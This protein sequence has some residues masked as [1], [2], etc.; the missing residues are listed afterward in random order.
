MPGATDDQRSGRTDM[1]ASDP[2]APARQTLE[3]AQE[4]AS[5]G[6]VREDLGTV[7]VRTVTDVFDNVVP[8]TLR[9]ET[10]EVTRHQV[11]R[12]VDVAPEPR[13]EGEVTII[14]V[15]EERA[16]VVTR[17]FVTE[18]VHIRRKVQEETAELPVSLRRQR[19]VVERFDANGAPRTAQP[20]DEQDVTG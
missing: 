13:T 20:G 11:D 2:R 1:A 9:A 5:V 4:F 18:E 7:R 15:V 3:I 14:P 16:V 6:V 10:I 19:A 12:E 8:A 17:L